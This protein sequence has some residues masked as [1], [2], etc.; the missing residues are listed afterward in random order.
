MRANRALCDLFGLIVLSA[1]LQPGVAAAGPGDVTGCT[2]P[3]NLSNTPGYASADPLLLADPAGVVHLFWAE[4]VLGQPDAQPNVPDTLLYS[5]WE[6]GRWSAP[7]DLFFSPRNVF[8]KRISGPSAVLDS[9]GTIHLIW[10]GP[11]YRLYYSSAPAAAAASARSWRPQQLVTVDQSGTQY[12]ADIAFG[13]PNTLHMLYGSGTGGAMPSDNRTN[14]AVTYIRSDDGGDTWSDPVDIYTF[15]DPSHGAS[16]VRL[17]ADPSGAVYATWTEWDSSGN[18][19]AIYFARSSDSGT[20]WDPAVVL[21]RRV[22]DEYERDWTALAKL[23]DDQL[24]AL[25][26][27]GF[28]AYPQ[29]QYSFNDGGAWSQPVDTFYWLIADN[30]FAEFERDSSGRLHVFLP[31]RIREGYEDRCNSFPGCTGDGNALWHSVWEGETRWREPRPAGDFLAENI[32]GNYTSAVITGGNRLMAAWFLYAETELMLMECRIEGAEEI[33]AQP[34][35]SPTTTP[36]P[37][38]TLQPIATVTLPAPTAFPTPPPITASGFT[39][40]PPASS[41]MAL[42]IPG[43]AAAFILVGGTIAIQ[44]FRRRRT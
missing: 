7:L 26:E 23:D 33:A 22:G 36:A 3:I 21:E 32:G 39:G 27:G 40:A 29:A 30:G 4:R 10:Q 16:N 9:A 28:R 18:G 6:N 19:Q 41:P 34:W 20:S 31:R 24:V 44:Q 12:S 11:D 2:M 13:P 1:L 42:I 8:N 37:S 5:R 43:L 35:P 14:R 17:L 38:P 15:T 25:W